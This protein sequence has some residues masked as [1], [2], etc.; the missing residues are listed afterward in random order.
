VIEIA[1]QI[2][3]RVELSTVESITT[4]EPYPRHIQSF[5][6]SWL[7]VEGL[8]RIAAAMRHS[9]LRRNRTAGTSDP[10]FLELFS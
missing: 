3:G 1:E 7:N 6:K 9:T 10:M 4:A 5:E 2:S 8:R